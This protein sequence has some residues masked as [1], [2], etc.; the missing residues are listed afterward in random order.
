MGILSITDQVRPPRQPRRALNA[1]GGAATRVR[2][3][4][5]YRAPHRAG[6]PPQA[7]G[8]PTGP[9][10][11]PG[12]ARPPA[13]LQ[14]RDPRSERGGRGCR[15]VRRSAAGAE[16]GGGRRWIGSGGGR[17]GGRGAHRSGGGPGAR[18]AARTWLCPASPRFPA[19][20]RGPFVPAPPRGP[21]LSPQ[22]PPRAR[23]GGSVPLGASRPLEGK[24][25]R[26]GTTGVQLRLRQNLLFLRP[27]ER[28]SFPADGGGCVG[29]H[30]T[31]HAAAV[32]SAT[33]CRPFLF[34]FCG[35]FF[36]HVEPRGAESA[37]FR[38]GESR[39][40]S[41]PGCAPRV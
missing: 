23:P 19:P 39:V 15:A 17:A 7:A 12:P 11:L 3:C 21:R 24:G 35:V 22:G 41:E 6:P 4:A 18:G 1:S 9:H 29:Q 14:R 26:G 36:F 20:L 34:Y 8:P 10:L 13:T 2:G 5:A 16:L 31:P 27:R 28:L 32:P 37:A 25:W 38:R 33:V 40:P 30:R